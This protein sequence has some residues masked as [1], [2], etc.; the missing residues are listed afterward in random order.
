MTAY[1]SLS[2]S[3]SFRCLQLNNVVP[4]H[5]FRDWQ[6]WLTSRVIRLKLKVYLFF[7]LDTVGSAAKKS[8]SSYVSTSKMVSI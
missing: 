6:T 4:G 3:W 1:L 2:L 7:N 8:V 5:I